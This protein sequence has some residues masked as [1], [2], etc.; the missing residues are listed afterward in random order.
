MGVALDVKSG[1]EN[2]Q[3][4]VYGDSETHFYVYIIAN[5][6]P[7]TPI[8]FEAM[9]VYPIARS[10]VFD[11]QN[12]EHFQIVPKTNNVFA[13]IWLPTTSIVPNTLYGWHFISVFKPP[14]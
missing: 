13:F 9:F 14:P 6:A 4:K 8:L 3:I 2:I 12:S 10:F 7:K 1:D 5:S 11:S